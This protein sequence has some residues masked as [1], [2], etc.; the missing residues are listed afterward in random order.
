M[1]LT[2]AY[3]PH[4]AAACDA[5]VNDWDVI[6]E[7]SLE[8][9]VEVLAAADGAQREAVGELGEHADFIRVFELRARRHCLERVESLGAGPV[10]LLLG[11]ELLLLWSCLTAFAFTAAV[12]LKGCWPS[13]AVNKKRSSLVVFNQR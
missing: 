8:D 3:P 13:S 5:G 1:L 4:K 9:A 7:F 11:V 10:L 6:R 2:Y 12:Y